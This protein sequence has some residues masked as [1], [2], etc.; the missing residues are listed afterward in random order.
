[1]ETAAA[2]EVFGARERPDG[3]AIAPALAVAA[4]ASLS[5]GAIHAAAAGVHS[6]NRAA[7][8]AFSLT[9]LVQLVWAV[10]AFWRSGRAVAWIGAAINLAAFGGWVLAKTAGISFVKGLDVKE[11]VGFPD[12]LCAVL[13][14]IAVIGAVLAATVWSRPSRWFGAFAFGGLAV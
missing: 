1:M 2:S 12:T 11:S 9:A 5:A 8:V 6:E 13:A 10:V 14:V 7:V 4:F 3:I